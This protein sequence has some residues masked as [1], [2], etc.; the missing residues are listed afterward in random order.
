M[1]GADDAGAFDQRRRADHCENYS[2]IAVIENEPGPRLDLAGLGEVD[3]AGSP[4]LAN[5]LSR[6]EFGRPGNTHVLLVLIGELKNLG[7]LL[8]AQE[9][10]TRLL[11]LPDASL[12]SDGQSGRKKQ[13]TNN[14]AERDPL[15]HEIPHD[16]DLTNHSE[17]YTRYRWLRQRTQY[18]S[19][20]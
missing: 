1:V 19:G 8:S 2:A 7:P 20:D 13:A 5:D 11:R 14:A 9:K 17:K 10:P 6:G 12:L 3:E 4:C 18:V 15:K 16:Y